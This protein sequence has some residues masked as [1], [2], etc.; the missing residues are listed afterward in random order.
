MSRI[1]WKIPFILPFVFMQYLITSAAL[2]TNHEINAIV[3]ATPFVITALVYGA[4]PAAIVY[5]ISIFGIFYAGGKDIGGLSPFNIVLLTITVFATLAGCTKTSGI[6]FSIK[7]LIKAIHRRRF[8]YAVILYL[9]LGALVALVKSITESMNAAPA[10]LLT[11]SATYFLTILFVSALYF[12]IQ[13]FVQILADMAEHLPETLRSFSEMWSQIAREL[14]PKTGALITMMTIY[15]FVCV[16][17]ASIYYYMDHC[18]PKKAVC[19]TMN[20]RAWKA[21]DGQENGRN[22]NFAPTDRGTFDGFAPYLYF[23]VVTSTTVGY[24]DI[25]P[26]SVCAIKIVTAHL[27]LSIILLI[28]L[29]GQVAGISLARNVGARAK[30]GRAPSNLASQYQPPSRRRLRRT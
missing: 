1:F 12:S 22:F 14:T 23:A 24:G 5:T 11:F 10:A 19:S 20:F 9:G 7:N 18:D 30:H 28:G 2:D 26:K 27:F 29:A 17:F 16:T 8:K 25:T 4:F 21:A 15:C 13:F 3:N 6:Y